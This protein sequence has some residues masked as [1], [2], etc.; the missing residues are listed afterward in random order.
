MRR[1]LSLLAL[2]VAACTPPA[3]RPSPAPVA[4]SD[5]IVEGGHVIDGTGSA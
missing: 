5:V 2:L 4:S 1:L 3:A